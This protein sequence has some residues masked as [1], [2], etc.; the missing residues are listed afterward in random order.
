MLLITRRVFISRGAILALDL[1]DLS[2]QTTL[3][4]VRD[5]RKNK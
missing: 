3:L 2:I 4:H 5:F 1:I